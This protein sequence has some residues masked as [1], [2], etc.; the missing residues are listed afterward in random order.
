MKKFMNTLIAL[1]ALVALSACEIKGSHTEQDFSAW[2]RTTIES[3]QI[4]GKQVPTSY[5][6]DCRHVTEAKNVHYYYN[7]IANPAGDES[8]NDKGEKVTTYKDATYQIELS[9]KT[10]IDSNGGS[11]SSTRGIISVEVDFHI[12]RTGNGTSEAFVVA[13]KETVKYFRYF[14]K[15]NPYFNKVQ[16]GDV[17]L[18]M[19]ANAFSRNSTNLTELDIPGLIKGDSLECR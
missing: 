7:L 8:F 6:F 5:I 12:V 10:P 19:M 15:K 2:N 1:S 17:L 13:N 9:T 3:R 14:L 11:T 4:D 16:E 18:H